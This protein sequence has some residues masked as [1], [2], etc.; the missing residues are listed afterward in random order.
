MALESGSYIDDLTIT[1]PVGTDS[2]S[3]GDDHLRLIKKVVKATFPGMAGAAWRVQ[4]KGAGYTVVANDNMT[5]FNCTAG[6]TLALTAAATLGNQHMFVVIGNGGAVVIDPNGAETING[7]S[8]ITVPD[9]GVALVFCNGSLFLGLLSASDVSAFMLTVLDDANASAARTTLG[10]AIGSDV[11]AFG[12]LLDDLNTLGANSSDSEFL[13]GTGSGALAW[14]SGA[15]ARTSIGVGTGDSPTFTN[16]TLT[17]FEYRSLTNTITAGSTQ[18]QGGATALTKEV[19]RVTV[20]GTDG[21]GVKLPTAVAGAMVTII[22]DDAAQTIQVW[23]NTDDA[24]DG[25]SAN[26]VD[27]NTLAFGS[28]REYIAVDATNWYTVTAASGQPLNANLTDIAA[29]TQVNGDGIM[30]DGTDYKAVPMATRKNLVINGSMRVAQR[31]TSVA[32]IGATN[33]EYHVQDRWEYRQLSD[34]LGRFTMSQETLASSDG[35][36]AEGHRMSMKLDCTTATGGIDAADKMVMG[37]IIEGQDL[38]MLAYGAASA[39]ATV[40]SFWHKHTKAGTHNVSLEFNNGTKWV[41]GQYTQSSTN[42]WEKAVVTFIGN[43]ADVIANDTSNQIR[44]KFPLAMGSNFTSGSPDTW[45]A[46]NANVAP[47]QVD[48]FDSTANNWEITGVQWELGSIDTPFEHLTYAEELRACDRYY[49]RYDFPSANSVVAGGFMN[50]TT[51]CG[52]TFFLR[53]Q[54]RAAPSLSVSNVADFQIAVTGAQVDTTNVVLFGGGVESTS[55][56][57]L[58]ATTGSAQ[59]AGDAAMIRTDA[60]GNRWLAVSAEL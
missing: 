14:E 10:V 15:T 35:P 38:Q 16:L 21:D 32:D 1:N 45:T 55:I 48:S 9:G 2:K 28:S 33:S 7:A 50:T 39:K 47:G 25:G 20:S 30:S 34:P 22:N 5:V 40:I 37:T 53:E 18:T 41:A 13:V 59:T 23:P 11:Q 3:A 57:G 17:G 51:R 46:T 4:A 6:L 29:I 26:A 24:I 36:Y 58:D 49:Q 42:T 31:S 27:S 44:V 8:S 43:T 56:I 52:A 19:N 54:M 12:A 60:T